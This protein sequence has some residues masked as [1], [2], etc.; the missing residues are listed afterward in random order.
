MGENA[1][2]NCSSITSISIPTSF[3]TI[4]EDTFW[5]DISI[6]NID[7]GQRN[8]KITFGPNAFHDLPSVGNITSVGS[9]NCKEEILNEFING[10]L[11]Q[12]WSVNEH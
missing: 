10:G 1:F 3:N 9:W 7:L 5:G 12:T 2:A 8:Q 4:K 6:T 11:S